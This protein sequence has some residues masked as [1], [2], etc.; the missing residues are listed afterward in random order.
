[1]SLLAE[2][3]FHLPKLRKVDRKRYSWDE[4]FERAERFA[5]GFLNPLQIK[6]E[7]TRFLET[8]EKLKPRYILE[9][10]TAQGGNFFLLAR[11][12]T[13][14]AT[15]IS[16]DLPGGP[17]GGG[18]SKW[19]TH[20]YRRLTLPGQKAYFL[21]ADS[22]APASLEDVKRILNGNELDLLFIDGDHSYEGVKRDYLMYSPLVRRGGLIA[23]HDIIPNLVP[24]CTVDRFWNELSQH[25]PVEEIVE[26]RN[27]GKMG[28]GI[29]RKDWEADSMALSHA[30]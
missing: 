3:L 11:S 10:G 21:R 14:D 7:A 27:Q 1:M 19:K 29:V 16:L 25:V 15:L 2:L 13:R 30:V 26:N 18:Y 4:I 17:L 23:F 8:A 20:V 12:A 22:H 24:E 28:I 5:N 6:S 9:I